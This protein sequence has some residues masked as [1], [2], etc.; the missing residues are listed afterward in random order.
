MSGRARREALS[1][2]PM[3]LKPHISHGI[4]TLAA[5]WK[6]N[7][8]F[9]DAPPWRHTIQLAHY[10]GSNHLLQISSPSL[11]PV[12]RAEIKAYGYGDWIVV[13]TNTQSR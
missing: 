4:Y 1:C 11:R 2:I 5:A 13:R 10:T 12:W 8:D 3:A 6:R 7:R 9:P